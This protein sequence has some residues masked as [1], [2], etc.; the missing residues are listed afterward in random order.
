MNKNSPIFSVSPGAGRVPKADGSGTITSWI[1][2][3]PIIESLKSQNEFLGTC[4]AETDTEAQ[5]KAALTAYVNTVASR[6]PRKGDLVNIANESEYNDQQWYF[7]GTDWIFYITFSS[8]YATDTVKGI[9]SVNTAQPSRLSIADGV[10]SSGGAKIVATNPSITPVGGIATWQISTSAYG[11]DTSEAIVQVD[12]VGTDGN[13][14]VYSVAANADIRKYSNRIA[15]SWNATDS[16]PAG[17]VRVV[18][19]A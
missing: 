13:E 6:N 14:A 17:S 9:L 19:L 4:T 18:I 10:L 8:P 12:I 2:S 1:G 11:L 16:I 3:D 5:L 15:V 7:N